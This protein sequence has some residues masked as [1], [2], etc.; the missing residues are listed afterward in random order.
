MTCAETRWSRESSRR[1]GAGVCA[2]VKRAPRA[3]SR[4][5][6]RGSYNENSRMVDGVWGVDEENGFCTRQNEKAG[7]GGGSSSWGSVCVS[8]PLFWPLV[9]ERCPACPFVNHPPVLGACVIFVWSCTQPLVCI[10]ACERGLDDVADALRESKQ[11]QATT[12]YK[13]QQQQ[14]QLWQTAG[15]SSTVRG[16]GLWRQ[17]KN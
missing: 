14:Q 15:F 1:R 12:V 16:S 9:V 5:S 10:N 2:V 3:R 8:T 6:I 7:R 4:R 13:Q 17:S 11:Q